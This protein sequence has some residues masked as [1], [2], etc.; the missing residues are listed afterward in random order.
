MDE[1]RKC[2]AGDGAS[3]PAEGYLEQSTIDKLDEEIELGLL[4]Q[5]FQQ[6]ERL[7]SFKGA[8]EL[9]IECAQ[10]LVETAYHIR[11]LGDGKKNAQ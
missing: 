9:Q 1:L 2:K 7:H 6:W 3:F 10:Q 8:K 5:F 11:E 4:R